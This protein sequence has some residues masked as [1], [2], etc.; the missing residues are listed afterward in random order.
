EKFLETKTVSD[1]YL[2][3][4]ESAIETIVIEVFE[5]KH[6]KSKY[7]DSLTKLF[8]A[9][10]RYHNDDPMDYGDAINA[11]KTSLEKQYT[12][13][14]ACMASW[15]D[16]TVDQSEN[17]FLTQFCSHLDLDPSVLKQSIQDIDNF[18][19]HNDNRIATL[20]SKN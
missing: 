16:K 13:D 11:L 12:I 14:L 2:Q 18:Y 8:M 19:S 15:T 10:R 6:Q 5:S 3:T 9:S 7:D 17:K 20:G 1:Q 4:I